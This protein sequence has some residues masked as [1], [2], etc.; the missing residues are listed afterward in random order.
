[1]LSVILIQDSVN[2]AGSS[3]GG[4]NGA[5]DSNGEING[6]GDTNGEINDFGDSVGGINESGDS[7]QWNNG[8][9]NFDVEI[10]KIYKPWRMAGIT[11]SRVTLKLSGWNQ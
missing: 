9:G 2:V 4:I 10:A 5:G 1:M 8:I 3:G 11:S 6:D 7:G